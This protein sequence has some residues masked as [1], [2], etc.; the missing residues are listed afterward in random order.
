MALM[1]YT[2][3]DNLVTHY[4]PQC[5]YCG[6]TTRLVFDTPNLAKDYLTLRF[7]R[8]GEKQ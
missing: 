7:P 4:Y 6:Y 3:W 5:H 1:S 8:L 2:D